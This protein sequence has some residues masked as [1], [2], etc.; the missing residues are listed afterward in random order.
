MIYITENFVADYLLKVQT[1][2]NQYAEKCSDGKWYIDGLI[3]ITK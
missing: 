1:F 2:L 3:K